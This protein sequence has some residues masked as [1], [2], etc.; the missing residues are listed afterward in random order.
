MIFARHSLVAVVTLPWATFSVL[1]MSLSIPLP[2][3][4]RS[5]PYPFSRLLRQWP[6]G[7]RREIHELVGPVLSDFVNIMNF[8]T[9]NVPLIACDTPQFLLS[10]QD[11]SWFQGTINTVDLDYEIV[12]PY[13]S[14]GCRHICLRTLLEEHLTENCR[15]NKEPEDADSVASVALVCVI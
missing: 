3:N 6:N 5:T 9:H 13:S 11:S 4:S 15:F 8:L 1:R 14:L 2:L 12:C 7:S 10:I